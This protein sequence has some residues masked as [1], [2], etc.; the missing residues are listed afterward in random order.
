MGQ[1]LFRSSIASVEIL[2]FDKAATF[3]FIVSRRRP[4]RFERID[5]NKTNKEKLETNKTLHRL[6]DYDAACIVGLNFDGGVGPYT[7]F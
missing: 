4:H 7:P 3:L 1:L 2:L 5:K 6:T